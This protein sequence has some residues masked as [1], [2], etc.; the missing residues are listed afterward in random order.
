MWVI[1]NEQVFKVGLMIDIYANFIVAFF[2]LHHGL[3]I[4]GWYYLCEQDS[5]GK[6]LVVK[7]EGDIK[8][9]I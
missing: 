2:S 6:I 7:K 9:E 5:P 1:G 4:D 8:K 3:E